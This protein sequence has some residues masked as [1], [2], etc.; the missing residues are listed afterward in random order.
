MLLYGKKIAFLGDSI[1]RGVWLDNSENSYVMRIKKSRQWAEVLNYSVPGS[2]IGEYIGEDP[3]NIGPSFVKR[4]LD[5]DEKAD[6]VIVF[7]GTND[8]GIGNAPLGNS[9]DDT[10]ETFYGAVNL[11]MKGLKNKYPKAIIIFATPL[12]RVT[13]NIPNQFSGAVLADYVNVIRKQAEKYGIHVLD[14]YSCVSLQPSEEYYKKLFRED[15]VHPNDLG[16]NV[17]A[18]EVLRFLEELN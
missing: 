10:P 12:H 6:I 4:Y 7:G 13:E 16:H 5:M 15:G 3:R 17:I 11:L 9:Q 14:L 8:F 2:R 18:E 1:T